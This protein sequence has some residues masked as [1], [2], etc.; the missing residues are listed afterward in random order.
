MIDMCD[1]FDMLNYGYVLKLHELIVWW[2][3]RMLYDC[4][5]NEI[6]WDNECKLNLVCFDIYVCCSTKFVRLEWYRSA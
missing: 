3:L 1:K 6:I 5:E 4:M 2:N